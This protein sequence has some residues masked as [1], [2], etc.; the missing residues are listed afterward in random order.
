MTEKQDNTKM[1]LK[2][3]KEIVSRM[4]ERELKPPFKI[5][6]GRIQKSLYKIPKDIDFEMKDGNT[7]FEVVGHFNPDGEEFF[8]N[9]IIRKLGYKYDEYE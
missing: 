8:I 3:V 9:Q 4:N 2:E 1:R 6:T 5:V 7:T